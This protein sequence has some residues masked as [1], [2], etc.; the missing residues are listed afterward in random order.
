MTYTLVTIAA[1]AALLTEANDMMVG[2]TGNSG[3]AATF[4]S[5]EWATED[6]G[7]AVI[8][9]LFDAD[10]V[11]SLQSPLIRFTGPATASTI[12]V[13]LDTPAPE[14]LESMGLTPWIDPDAPPPPV[15]D[16]SAQRLAEERAGMVV[17]RLQG[18]LTL[19]PAT[20]AAL[21]QIAADEMT[22]WA[23]RETIKHAT[24]WRRTSQAMDELGYVLGYAPGQMDALFR[25]AAEV[26]V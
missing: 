14:A 9:G 25:A 8:S 21:D 17:T 15:V 7:H 6:T 11:A 23:M 10:F 12:S 3:D 2:L 22:P 5:L 13:R 16:R 1:P 18:R 4:A 20:C 19:G 24:E 26:T